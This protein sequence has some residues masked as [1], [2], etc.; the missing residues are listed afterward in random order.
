MT[1]DEILDAYFPQ[2]KTVEIDGNKLQELCRQLRRAER[3]RNHLHSKLVIAQ[4]FLDT[5]P[6]YINIVV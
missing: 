4:A 3:E 5:R 1:V 2:G 6:T